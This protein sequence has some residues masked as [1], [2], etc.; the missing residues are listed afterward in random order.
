MAKLYQIAIVPSALIVGFVGGSIARGCVDY[1]KT[2]EE[3]QEH[4]DSGRQ[5]GL[6]ED[7]LKGLETERREYLDK[8]KRVCREK[9]HKAYND[10]LNACTEI[11]K[12]E[13]QV[14]DF[15]KDGN[16]DVIYE[17]PR[18]GI[19]VHCID[20]NGDG[21]QDA[22]MKD[23]YGERLQEAFGNPNFANKKKGQPL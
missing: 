8:S 2:S 19:Q 7:V 9:I 12:L 10:G 3:T 16:M 11:S 23:K 14:S 1:Q 20:D 5:E 21:A 17:N 4:F 15:N 13:I 22:I 6:N 18:N